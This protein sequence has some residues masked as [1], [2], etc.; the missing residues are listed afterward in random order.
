MNLDVTVAPVDLDGIVDSI[1]SSSNS[2][3]VSLTRR[4]SIAVSIQNFDQAF[5]NFTNVA[6]KVVSELKR[7]QDKILFG[8]AVVGAIELAVNSFL[9]DK[10]KYD[11]ES[12]YYSVWQMTPRA[13]DDQY[14]VERSDDKV[15]VNKKWIISLKKL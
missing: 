15:T 11:I 7:E 9:N 14:V 8:Q 3:Q 2:T 10:T 6:H 13:S 5:N 4:D 1:G 12:A